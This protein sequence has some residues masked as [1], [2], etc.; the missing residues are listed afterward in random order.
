M[1]K[2]QNPLLLL[3]GMQNRAATLGKIGYHFL[4]GIL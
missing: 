4:D 2:I 3:V 1:W